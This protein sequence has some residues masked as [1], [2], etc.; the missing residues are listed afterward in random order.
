MSCL[1]FCR[2]IKVFIEIYTISKCE[3]LMNVTELLLITVTCYNDL[4]ESWFSSMCSL[5]ICSI[6]LF[7]FD[8]H[9]SDIVKDF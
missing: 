6:S 4:E 3:N 5:T 2:T 1:N 9:F 8:T 7:P